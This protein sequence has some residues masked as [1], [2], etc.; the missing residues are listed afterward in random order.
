M[1]WHGALRM[2]EARPF[3]GWGIGS[4][5]VREAL[6]TELGDTPAHVLAHGASHNNLAHNF[7]LQTAAEVGFI[8][9]ALY[10]SVIVAFFAFGL[11][12]LGQM[13]KKSTSAAFPRMVLIGCLA[14][15]AGQ[16]VDAFGSPAYNFASVSL[17]QW[18]LLG[19]GTAAARLGVQAKT[20]E[21]FETKFTTKPMSRPLRTALASA[22]ALAILAFVGPSMEAA[23]SDVC[24]LPGSSTVF[25]VVTNTGRNSY[26]VLLN[27]GQTA[28]LESTVGGHP[29]VANY[30]VND[31]SHALV[32]DASGS[33]Y[34][35]TL[36]RNATHLA[37]PSTVTIDTVYTTKGRN[38]EIDFVVR[39]GG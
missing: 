13:Q 33:G 39:V 38:Y 4:F 3:F 29:V 10:L 37:S 35:F 24:S 12:S 34:S 16:V 32:S 20:A 8:G 1:M 36:E 15:M 27:P 21:M 7:Y 25:R 5:P 17:F 14:A 19:V 31:P 9:L 11:R 26:N 28:L 22:A 23:F 6:F 30:T 18:V 2:A